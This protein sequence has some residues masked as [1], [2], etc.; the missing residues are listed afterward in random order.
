MNSVQNHSFRR[1]LCKL[2]LGC[3]R[4]TSE[5]GQ[6]VAQV[7]VETTINDASLL[8][9]YTGAQVLGSVVIITVRGLQNEAIMYLS[10]PRS[11]PP[12]QHFL[13]N[14]KSRFRL[15][16]KQETDG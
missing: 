16:S 15:T 3:F 1:Q 2:Y 7:K 14:S 8:G 12:V 11:W 9:R 10:E 13:Q 4:V 5:P 6:G